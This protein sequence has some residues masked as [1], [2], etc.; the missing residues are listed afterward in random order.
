MRAGQQ[1]A[2]NPDRQQ[3]RRKPEPQ[4]DDGGKL[5]VS[6]PHP[7]QRVE[8]QQRG[9]SREHA[10]NRLPGGNLEGLCVTNQ[11]N[12]THAQPQQHHPVAYLADTQ[13]HD[14]YGDEPEQTCC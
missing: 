1:A 8:R 4:P 5:D 14:G 7:A 12:D 3:R 6:R 2:A 9:K 10:Q 13:I 11:G